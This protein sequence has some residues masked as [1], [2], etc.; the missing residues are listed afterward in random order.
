[1]RIIQKGTPPMEPGNRQKEINPIK[2]VSLKDELEE[3]EES[4]ERKEV[5]FRISKS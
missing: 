1:M 3:T 4:S 2:N 5:R